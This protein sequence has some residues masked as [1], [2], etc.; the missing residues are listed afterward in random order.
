MG[1]LWRAIIFC[2][3]ISACSCNNVIPDPA[4]TQS[5]TQGI[6]FPRKTTT[7]HTT[8]HT[9]HTTTAQ[10]TLHTNHTTTP[11]TTL[12]TN[13]TTTPQTTV[14]TNHTTTPYTT[15]HTNHTTTPYTTLRT[16]HTTPHTTSHTNHTT[17]HNTTSPHTQHTTQHPTTLPPS[18]EYFVNSTSE[19]CLRIRASFQIQVN[20]TRIREIVIPPPPSTKASGNCSAQNA[21]LT[22]T[23]PEGQLCLTFTQNSTDNKFY[24]GAINITLKD[25]VSEQ[26]S[27]TSLKAMVTPLGRSFSC[28]NVDVEVTPK[29][30]FVAMD[31]KAQAFKLEGGN[32]G[33]EL[34]CNESP[35]NMTVPIVIGV[36]LLV[37]V[38]IV[39]IAY[40]IARR[41]KHRGYQTL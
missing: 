18:W 34:K 7:R 26:F 31:V 9:S 33:R 19:V 16:N 12:H 25:R 5:T 6:E 24:L 29:V 22:L 1:Y 11:Q 40:V 41:Q 20:D 4:S 32:Y 15:L 28:E 35:R 23:F 27:N 38:L 39:V 36:I 30:N 14:H 37:L 2:V 13:H 10:T 21:Q 8:Q 17:P 3:Y